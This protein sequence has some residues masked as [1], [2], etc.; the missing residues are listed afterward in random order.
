MD[1][2]EL[3]KKVRKIEIKTRG[4]TTQVFTGEYHAAF[5]GKGMAFSEVR[6]YQP[7]DEIRT[8][9]WNVTARF[10][11]PFVKV[12]QEERELSVMLLVDMS[13]SGNFGTLSSS[14]RELMAEIAAVLAFSAI[15][16]N[17]KIGLML[18]TRY[19]ELFIP[20]KKGKSHVLRIIREI[21]DFEPKKSGTDI[22]SAVRNFANTIK[23]RSVGFLL[24]DFLDQN[25]EKALRICN[26]RHDLVA[27]RISDPRESD[28]PRVGWLQAKDPETGELRWIDTHSATVRKK[29]KAE[30][31]Q[32][33]D[34]TLKMLRRSGVDFTSIQTGD[35]YIL[36]LMKLFKQ[37]ERAA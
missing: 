18:F 1:T 3:L 30:A 4:L 24:T 14:K 15:Q 22:A 13:A 29:Y 28:L 2:R 9:D 26:S 8:I 6:E 25:C 35:D 37:R 33:K 12:F 23:R 36:P 20:P 34:E 10:N 17:D 16:N 11:H 7:G 5:K 32:R 27:V 21:I 19:T 31:L